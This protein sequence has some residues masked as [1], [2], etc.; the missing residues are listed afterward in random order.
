[1]DRRGGRAV[2]MGTEIGVVWLQAK[3]FQQLPE[4]IRVKERIVPWSLQKECGP[5]DTLISAQ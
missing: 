1:M 4:A 2:T 5:H 3:Q